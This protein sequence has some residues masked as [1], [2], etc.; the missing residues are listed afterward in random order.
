[1]TAM[2]R[3]ITTMISRRVINHIKTY[4]DARIPELRLDYDELLVIVSVVERSTD[5]GDDGEVLTATYNS[6][7]QTIRFELAIPQQIT[8]PWFSKFLSV[9]KKSLRHEL[10]HYLQHKRSGSFSGDVLKP[11][12]VIQGSFKGNPEKGPW[13]SVGMAARYLLNPL[14]VEAHVV[15]LWMEAKYRKVKFCVVLKE[16][17]ERI[18]KELLESNFEANLVGFLT[19]RVYEIWGF[20]ALTRF[21][22]L[23]GRKIRRGPRRPIGFCR[24]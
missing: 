6:L 3:S 7:S 22:S 17:M 21:P 13:T 18:T 15:G 4:S 23:R 10:E 8:G 11:L 12:L 2:K 1:M 14:E 20:Y 5:V 16:A 9:F 24:V 19:R